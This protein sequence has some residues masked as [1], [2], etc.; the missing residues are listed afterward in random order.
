MIISENNSRRNFLKKAGTATTVLAGVTATG[1]S[2]STVDSKEK[3]KSNQ[4][5]LFKGNPT[6][7]ADRIER[8]KIAAIGMQRYDWEQG[9][10]AQAFLE[11]GDYD[12]M[13]SFARAAIMR[14]ENG[15][16]SVLKGNGPITD[17]SSVGKAVLFSGELTGDPM[18]KKPISSAYISRAK[19]DDM[20]KNEKERLNDS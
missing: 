10:L 17:C 13:I 9:T 4:G 6:S 15:R 18:F 1:F 11:C 8:V 16:F 12:M 2:C 14:Q 19:K 20:S 3:V 5:I 7:L